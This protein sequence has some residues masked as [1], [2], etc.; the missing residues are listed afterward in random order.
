MK[1]KKNF[2]GWVLFF[3]LI[4]AITLRLFNLNWDQSQ[5]LHPDERFITMVASDTQLPDSL[6]QYFNTFISPLNPNNQGY[7]FYAYGIFPVLLTKIIANFF[8]FISY[9]Q[10]FLIGRILS[11]VFDTGIILILYSLS[12]LL[13]FNSKTRL[14][15]C[16]LYALAI[17]PIQL[18][19]FFTVDT[20]TIFFLLLSAFFLIKFFKTPK[21][22]SLLLSGIFIGIG[23]ACKTSIVILLP[24]FIL[25]IFTK[26]PGIKKITYPLF[27]IF[28]V[29]LAFRIFQPYAF[30]SI[31][32]PSS[33]FLS[34]IVS[35]KQMI[36]GEYQYPPNIQWYSTLPLIHPLVNIFL[37][38]LGPIVSILSVL[39]FYKIFIKNKSYKDFSFLFIIFLIVLIFVYQ[40]VQL[41]KYMRYFYPIYPLLII[42]AGVGLQML[43]GVFKKIIIFLNIIFTLFFLNIYFQENSRITASKWIYQN[44]SIGSVLS[45]EYWDDSLPLNLDSQHLQLNYNVISLHLYDSDT[46]QK[47][48]QIN[49][50]LDQIDYLILS[51]NRLWRSISNDKKDYPSTSQFYQSLFDQNSEFKLIKTFYSYPGVALPFFRKCFLVGLSDYPS[52]NN[53]FFEIDS[54]CSSPGI[55]FR[56]NIAEESFTVYDHPQVFIFS[57]L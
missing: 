11:A 55:Y 3:I 52:Q 21:V 44:I 29:F 19:H 33:Q 38:G 20:F 2:S 18:S 49:K 12:K 54:N 30:D 5:H 51:S 8:N 45:S 16:F 43:S 15:I 13:G 10:I 48:D 22:D 9:E 50:S 26:T 1:N 37:F 6:S 17:F 34:S 28:P 36:T 24:L 7:D 41:A 31:F 46:S 47:W 42:F 14:S 27:F 57:R 53:S 56:D 39:G 32:T 23:L 4:L 25:F 35:A 40:G